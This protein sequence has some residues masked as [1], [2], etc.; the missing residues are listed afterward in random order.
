M[1]SGMSPSSVLV[2]SINSSVTVVTQ[3]SQMLKPIGPSQNQGI[4]FI[5]WRMACHSNSGLFLWSHRKGSAERTGSLAQSW[6][7]NVWLL[8]LPFLLLVHARTPFSLIFLC[9]PFLHWDS[10]SWMV[11]DDLS[12]PVVCWK[13]KEPNIN[14]LHHFH[15]VCLQKVYFSALEHTNQ[16]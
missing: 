6:L 1:H 13:V 8:P 5:Q 7:D 2:L 15:V 10:C 4:L 16:T 14:N 11:H 3:A 9:P 12:G